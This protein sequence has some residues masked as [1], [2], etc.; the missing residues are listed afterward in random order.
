VNTYDP[1]DSILYV[2]MTQEMDPYS[3]SLEGGRTYCRLPVEYA[4]RS[5]RT[6]L[7]DRFKSSSAGLPPSESELVEA[8]P[9]DQEA[10]AGRGRGAGGSAASAA[11]TCRHRPVDGDR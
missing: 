3:T 5:S 7:R 1:A 6:C 10:R 4:N 11:V 9:G 2:H 8:G